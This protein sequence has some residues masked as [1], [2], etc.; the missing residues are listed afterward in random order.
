MKYVDQRDGTDLD[1][2]H[3]SLLIALT[4]RGL[5]SEMNRRSC[6]AH[7]RPP[8]SSEISITEV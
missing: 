3:T 8:D 1:P 4:S 7:R 5:P 2:K 6:P